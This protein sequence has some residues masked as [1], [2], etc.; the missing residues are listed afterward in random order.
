ME[1]ASRGAAAAGGHVIGVT[2]PEVFAARSRANEYVAEEITAPSLTKRIDVMLEM[3]AASI[4]LDGSIGTLTELIVAWNI[5]FVSRF[6]EAALRPVVAV[7]ARWREIVPALVES[8]DTD[9][10]IVT[11]VDSA[12]AAVAAVLAGLRA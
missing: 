9:G 7:G 2:A 10:S 6:S 11:V 8:L 4:A 3:A 12:D 1:G 5:A